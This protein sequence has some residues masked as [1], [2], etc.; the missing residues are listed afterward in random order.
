[1]GAKYATATMLTSSTVHK[2]KKKHIFFD[3][4]AIDIT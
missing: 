1:M 3:E 2:K 4:K